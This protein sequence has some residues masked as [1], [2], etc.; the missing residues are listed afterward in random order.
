MKKNFILLS[1]LLTISCTTNTGRQ[2]VKE[3]DKSEQSVIEKSNE[4]AKRIN[5]NLDNYAI[6]DS[7]QDTLDLKGKDIY[8]V[9][10][11]KSVDGKPQSPVK[12]FKG[13]SFSLISYTEYLPDKRKLFHRYY[14]DQNERIEKFH[15]DKDFNKLIL[16]ESSGIFGKNYYNW[17][18]Y[19]N[20]SYLIENLQYSTDKRKSINYESYTRYNIGQQDNST[21]VEIREYSN[22]TLPDPLRIYIF[23]YPYLTKERPEYQSKFQKFELINGTYKPIETKG[24][25]FDDRFVYFSYDDKGFI[26]SEIWY[27]PQNKLENKTEY[28]YSQDYKERTEQQY[29]M[30]GTEKSLKTTRKYDEHN[31][32]ISEHSI[33][34][35]GN[36][37]G[38][39]IYEYTYDKRG[40]WTEKK[41]Y[42]QPCENGVYGEKKL[43]NH[44]IREIEYYKT[45]Q[46]PRQFNLPVLPEEIKD[47]KS[48][49]P[50]IAKE[51]QTLEDELDR[52]VEDGNYDT[53]ITIKRA[54]SLDDF[55]PRYWKIIDKA[56]GN[57]DGENGDEAIIVYNVPT[58]DKGAFDRCLAIFRKENNSWTLWHQTTSPIM[59]NQ[60]GGV[61]GDPFS[62][63]KIEKRAIVIE[64]FGGSRQKWQYTHRYRFQDN[65]W[66]LIGASS[67]AGAPCDYFD[68]LDYNL[69]TGEAI[70]KY[71]VEKCDDP[72][73]I[74]TSWT[75][76]LKLKTDLPRMGEFHPGTVEI[77][78]P[79]RDYSVYY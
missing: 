36:Q 51:K 26:T 69:S 60:S 57:L 67:S 38:A 6:S 64:H 11:Y 76:K 5:E 27:K 71:W 77:A 12:T 30:L 4:L 17:L 40:N 39:D 2:E 15:Y 3:T 75:E 7:Y 42:Y 78:V 49:I 18:A 25:I 54:S 52:A 46:F 19:D 65:D 28:Y 61:W 72:D 10:Y 8:S 14:Y 32:L 50:S 31:N 53:S 34:Y 62:G 47:L 43:I 68:S 22:D 73:E 48:R 13:K 63:V 79:K 1:L 24:Y 74:L 33:E 23:S 58:S 29:H 55:T 37:L 70:V 59:D 35:T 21:R 20:D 44:E 41:K 45:G 66:Y 9:Y 56:Y 16:K